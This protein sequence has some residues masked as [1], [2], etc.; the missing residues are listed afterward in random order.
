MPRLIVAGCSLTYGSEIE[1]PG[2]IFHDNPEE[3]FSKTF[4]AIIANKIGMDYTIVA[5]PGASNISI[6]RALIPYVNNNSD[7]VIVVCWTWP[8]RVNVPN[9]NN[10]PSSAFCISP[11]SF[12]EFSSGRIKNVSHLMKTW[13]DHLLGFETS[14]SSLEAFYIINSLS[15]NTIININMGNFS[16]GIESFNGY[17]VPNK[18]WNSAMELENHPYY[19]KFINTKIHFRNQSLWSIIDEQMK[20]DPELSSGNFHMSEKGHMW[21]ANFMLEQGIF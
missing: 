16:N 5:A 4:S 8:Q 15:K 3:S 1:S 17:V 18:D 11:G 12:N 10:E 19:H 14:I 7:D 2:K 6:A 21:M 20:I 9:T 13:T